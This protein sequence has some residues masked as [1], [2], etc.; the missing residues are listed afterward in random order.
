MMNFHSLKGFFGT[1]RMA[2]C[3]ASNIDTDLL[4][5]SGY[6]FDIRVE[7][8]VRLVHRALQRILSVYKDEKRGPTFVAVQSTQG[9]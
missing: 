6:L 4:P 9:V 8:D 7:T 2:T 1:D 5:V 3:A